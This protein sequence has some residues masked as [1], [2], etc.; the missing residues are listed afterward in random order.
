MARQ[1]KVIWTET[2]KTEFKKTC[3]YWNKRNAS[4][5][6]S[7]RL[8][9]LVQSAIENISLY[10]QSGIPSSF[11]KV[12]FVVIRDYLLFY[13]FSGGDLILL[14]FWDARQ[15]PDKLKIRLT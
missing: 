12:R 5:A 3:A 8:R 15:D 10:P 11:E 14:S 2:A 1:G 9:K 7:T 13:Q 6:Y 4:N